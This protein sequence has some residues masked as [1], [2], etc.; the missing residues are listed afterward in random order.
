MC[1]SRAMNW[2]TKGS[3]KMDAHHSWEMMLPYSKIY[4][5]PA[6][7]E[8]GFDKLIISSFLLSKC[9][10]PQILSALQSSI[11]HQH[12]QQLNPHNLKVLRT[13][14]KRYR[15]ASP[16]GLFCVNQ[17]N[18]CFGL[19]AMLC[20]YWCQIPRHKGNH[21]VFNSYFV[22]VCDMWAL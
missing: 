22:C 17:K 12:R 15:K 10:R 2:N 6:I 11:Y 4:C 1:N 14:G 5:G 8:E 21:E 16:W 7:W 18:R 9:L 19:Q 3:K 13:Q 20:Q